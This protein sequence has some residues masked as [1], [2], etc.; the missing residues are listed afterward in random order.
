[1]EFRRGNTRQVTDEAQAARDEEFRQ[2]CREGQCQERLHL[3]LHG[4]AK[5]ES[6]DKVELFLKYP[7]S[8]S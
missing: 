3:L 2:A 4:K 5:I 8:L 7:G 6:T 1:M